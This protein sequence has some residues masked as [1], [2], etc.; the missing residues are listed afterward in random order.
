M[1][2]KEDSNIQR[3]EEIML[4]RTL[5]L[6]PEEKEEEEVESS[7]VSHVG[8]MGTGHLSVQRKIKME[9]KLTS[10]R[11]RGRMLRSKIQKAEGS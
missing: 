6:V 10:L 8:R 1:L 9:E 4:T 3:R 7:H 2:N 5:F 11:H